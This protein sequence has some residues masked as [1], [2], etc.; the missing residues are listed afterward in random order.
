MHFDPKAGAMPHSRDLY[1]PKFVLVPVATLVS[2]VSSTTHP[3]NTSNY[4]L[5]HSGSLI[6]H[7]SRSARASITSVK[8]STVS[9][10]TPLGREHS[11]Y[12][13]WD[14]I[15]TSYMYQGAA[16]KFDPS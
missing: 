7:E 5:P 2:R 14:P 1:V 13:E 15:Y 12:L 4:S 9:G 8:E 11:F 10:V 6:P 16:P 3:R